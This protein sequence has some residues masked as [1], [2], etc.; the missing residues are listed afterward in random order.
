MS[1][2]IPTNYLSKPSLKPFLTKPK[3]TTII[4]SSTAPT[5]SSAANNSTD[6]A[7]SKLKAFSAALALSSILLSAPLPAAADISGLTPCK[8]SKQFAKRQKQSIKK[9]E[10]SLK[11]YAPDSAPALAIK[12]TIEKTKRRFENYGKQGLLCGSDGLPHLI[13]SGDQR[14]WGEFITPGILFLYI[15]GWIGWVGRSYLIAIRDDKKPTQKEIIID[16][17]LA[18]RLVFRGFSWP[19]AAYRELVTGELIAKDV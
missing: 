9:L 2:T 6:T 17:P 5:P 4:C 1:L 10:S 7:D 12:A 18:T 3:S 14:H 13:V 11:N 19:I 15:A 8:E 16:V